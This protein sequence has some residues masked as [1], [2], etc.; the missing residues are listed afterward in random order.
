MGQV[1][2]LSLLLLLLLST[3]II[4]FSTTAR[5]ASSAVNRKSATT[6]S[7]SS[8]SRIP[9][10]VGSYCVSSLLLANNANE[11][12]DNEESGSFNLSSIPRPT[13]TQLLS[14]W[15][16]A[17][18]G[19]RILESIPS[20]VIEGNNNNAP[21]PNIAFNGILFV[22]G[23]YTLIQSVMG[24]KYE[25]LEDL[26]TKSWARQAGIF[27]LEGR[28]PNEFSTAVVDDDVFPNNNKFQV[29]TFAG[30][31]FWGTELRF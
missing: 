19:N 26:D 15:L 3:T 23:L 31:C 4:S 5:T 29:A 2:R 18:A 28:V 12:N 6:S 24:I 9:K 25:K 7:S 27:A 11:N 21:T 16:V 22:G 1:L 30:G 10:R 8:S 13:V 20:V 14:A 17:I